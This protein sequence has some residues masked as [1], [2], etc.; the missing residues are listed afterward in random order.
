MQDYVDE[1]L[2]HGQR[3]AVAGGATAPCER[4]PHVMV[5]KDS[6]RLE[7]A[8]KMGNAA[9]TRGELDV[10]RKDLTDAIKDVFDQAAYD[11]PA[12]EKQLAE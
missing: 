10:G 11:C 2:A 7:A 9:V 6:E 8:Y 4:H 1:L 12:C 3:F 5:M